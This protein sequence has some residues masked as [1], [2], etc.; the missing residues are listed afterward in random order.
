MALIVIGVD[1][2]TASL[3]VR[4]QLA[5]T[6]QQTLAILHAIAAERIFDEALILSTCNRTE[7]YFDPGNRPVSL[8]HLLAHVAVATASQPITDTSIFFQYHGTD[9]VRHL[10][11]VAAS[12]ESQILG[13]HEIMG[14]L[15]QAYLLSCEART[16]KFLLHKL[17]HRAF[18]VGKRIQ[19]DTM[20]GRGTASVPQAAVDLAGQALGQLA[21]K[22]VMLIGAGQTAELSAGALL[23][24]GIGKLIVA[25]RSA[26]PAEQLAQAFQQWHDE[27]PSRRDAEVDRYI[28]PALGPMLA[29]C[30]LRP[31]AAMARPA[32]QVQAISLGEID[33]HI[34][35]VD[36][37][38]SSTLSA[39]PILTRDRLAMPLKNLRHPLLII[40]IAVPRDVEPAVGSL[41]GVFLHNI[42][43]LQQ[44]VDSNIERRRLEVPKAQAIVQQAVSDFGNWLASLDCVPTIRQLEGR[45]AAIQQAELAKYR[46]RISA[47]DMPAFQEFARTLCNKILHDPLVFLRKSGGE[48]TGT[49]L[50][51]VDVL[52]R[53]FNLDSPEDPS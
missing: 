37:V 5:L 16:S 4:E 28:C 27:P 29:N 15:K 9:A 46:P 23:R 39:E 52:R 44:A 13:E 49:S 45:L 34:A 30:P 19:T 22:T 8:T 11:R 21:G 33:E 7:F 14:Q 6:P 51:D 17:M 2:K 26:Q 20:L 36:L 50:A 12:L 43:D 24:E 47:G 3:T 53:I 18:R 48:N 42:D 41:P 10:F 1:F 32:L 40:D 31:T 35:G 38:I 25:N